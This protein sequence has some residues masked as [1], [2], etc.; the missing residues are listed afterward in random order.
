MFQVIHLKEKPVPL[1]QIHLTDSNTG[2]K[3]QKSR[4]VT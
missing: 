2:G 1:V 3:G 4:F